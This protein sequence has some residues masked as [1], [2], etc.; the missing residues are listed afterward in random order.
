MNVKKAAE[1]FKKK[2]DEFINH[3]ANLP[4]DSPNE[5]QGIIPQ[6]MT[7][8]E[9]FYEQ[10]VVSSYITFKMHD[11]SAKCVVNIDDLMDLEYKY[12][13]LLE[14]HELLKE[15]LG[16]YKDEVD[17]YKAACK[18]INSLIANRSRVQT[19]FNNAI[20]KDDSKSKSYV[21]RRSIQFNFN[22]NEIIKTTYTKNHPIRVQRRRT[23][24][25]KL[26]ENTVCVNR[27]TK[28]GN[29][30]KVIY[31]DKSWTVFKVALRKPDEEI[32]SY[33][34]KEL[35][36]SA[37]IK[38]YTSYIHGLI[39]SK[40]LDITELKGKNLACFCSLKSKCHSDVL[41]KLAYKTYVSVSYDKGNGTFKISP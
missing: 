4:L 3:M 6:P 41:L 24:G 10:E 7:P 29:P 32:N 14:S 1:V 11:G 8:E 19:I 2:I 30:Y 36:I 31:W 16:I 27:G 18:N 40:K 5:T 20:I 21:S 26:P 15:E 25:Y 38:L 23:K 39:K 22:N 28:W 37:S 12:I 13:K 9:S 33:R 34:S 35:A 17:Y